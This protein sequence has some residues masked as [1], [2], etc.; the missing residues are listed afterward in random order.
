M[1]QELEASETRASVIPGEGKHTPPKHMYTNGHR[2]LV[3]T[4]EGG[5][6]P[7]VHQL[8]RGQMG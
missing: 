6:H 2:M 3:I 5:S 8:A 7:G 1:R 4:A